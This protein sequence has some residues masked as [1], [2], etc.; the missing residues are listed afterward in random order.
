MKQTGEVKSYLAS[1]YNAGISNF[2][3][4][5]YYGILDGVMNCLFNNTNLFNIIYQLELLKLSN[6]EGRFYNDFQIM[7]VIRMNGWFLNE[8]H[9]YRG[10]KI[11]KIEENKLTK[12][13][14]CGMHV[15]MG[16]DN[17][18]KA[19]SL[20]Y[21]MLEAI[22]TNNIDRFMELL[23]NAYL[24]LDKTVH[25]IFIETQSETEVF[26]DYAF[27]FIAGLIGNSEKE[28]NN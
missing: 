15:R 28:Q 5:N 25:K 22:R 21:K 27:A 20:A 24:Y 8:L 10:S 11:M 12:V 18:N 23:L 9:K 13:R 1:L 19:K 16:Y 3:G 14:G 17:E 4:V 2:R 6:T 7:T 26:K